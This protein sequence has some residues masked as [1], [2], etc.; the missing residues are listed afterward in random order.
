MLRQCG[1]SCPVG[2][3]CSGPRTICGTSVCTQTANFASTVNVGPS[4]AAA[5]NDLGTLSVTGEAYVY[6]KLQVA[7]TQS[8]P[9]Q[10]FSVLQGATCIVDADVEVGLL[11]P[12]VGGSLVFTKGDPTEGPAPLASGGR[13]DVIYDHAGGASADAGFRYYDATPASY[14]ARGTGV[15]YEEKYGPALGSNAGLLGM[16]ECS[17]QTTVLSA[18]GASVTQLLQ[19]SAGVLGRVGSADYSAWGTW[20]VVVQWTP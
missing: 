1:A 14:L 9:D 8:L 16:G 5:L 19:G 15:Y 17:L 6:G 2:Y 20:R 18:A 3:P 11:A 13:L 12:D 4:P 7:P 10:G